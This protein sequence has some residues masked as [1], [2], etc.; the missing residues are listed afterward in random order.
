MKNMPSHKKSRTGFWILN[1]TTLYEIYL[2]TDPRPGLNIKASIDPAINVCESS[3]DKKWEDTVDDK[4][5]E[6]VD[7]T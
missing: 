2:L 1:T 3:E 7:L 4:W 6:C 5:I